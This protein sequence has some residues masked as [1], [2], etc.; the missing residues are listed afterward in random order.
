MATTVANAG[1]ST[2]STGY[3]IDEVVTIAGGGG[4]ATFKVIALTWEKGAEKTSEHPHIASTGQKVYELVEVVAATHTSGQLSTAASNMATSQ[5]AYTNAVTAEASSK[6]AYNSEVTNCV[7]PGLPSN[8]YLRGASADDIELVTLN[9]YTYVLNKKKTVALKDDLTDPVSTDAFIVIAVTA[10]NSKYEVIINGV[11]ITYT[12]AEDAG[13]GDAD[14]T[15]IVSNLVTGINGAGGAAASCVATAVGPGIHVTGVTSIAVAGGPQGGAIYSFINQISDISLL[16]L[17]CVHNYKVKVIN[18]T[19]IDADDMWVRFESGSSNYASGTGSWVESNEPASKFKLDPSTMPHQLVRETDGSFKFSEIAWENRDV[20]DDVTNPVPSFVG[21]TI[22]NMFFF[23]NRFGLLSGGNVILSK[24]GS[25]YDFWAGSAMVAI[26]DDPIDISASSTK[27]VFL[28]YVKTTSAGLAM[29][30]DS[31]QFLLSTDSDILSPESAKVNTLSDYECDTDIQA[32]NLGT[33][34]AFISKTPLY[35]RLFELANISTTDPPTSFN[36]TGIVP[37]LVPST[38]DNIAGSPGMSIISLGTTGSSTL[39]QYRFYQTAEKR[40]ASTWYKWDLTGNLIDQFFD[41][42]TFYTVISDGTNVSIMS[43]DLRQASDEGFL[44]LS[45]GEKT[46]VCMDYY[47][48]NPYR[49]YHKD[50][51]GSLSAIDANADKT[52][53]YLPFTHHTGKTLAVVALGGYIGGTLGATEAS[54]GA[55][56]YPTVAGSAG[57]EYVDISGDYR[58]KNIIIGYIYT[59]TVDLPK[60]Y[61][62]SGDPQSGK[63]DYTS[64]LIIHRV[65]ISTGLSGPVKYNVNLTGI[66]DRSQTVSAIMPY[67][68]TANDVAMAA[69]GVHEV[70]VYQR[71]ENIS[72]SIVGDTPLPVSLLGMTWEGKYNNKFYSHV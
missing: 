35:T 54:V 13:A 61:Y 3:K 64:D 6:T 47:A 69:E 28:N 5:T 19:N 42:S 71:N 67:T 55:V 17:Q 65:K 12:T 53:V 68:Y 70:P 58:G 33:S 63:A 21:S 52:R 59:M 39:Y 24:A 30:S 22:R 16:P 60:F 44:T 23:R 48:T 41:V 37:E 43:F 7:I 31:E 72:F 49:R 38:V 15:V 45:T 10:Y 11:S 34:L 20:G 2:S 27:P 25:F 9:D 57:S 66:P 36:T 4:N 50:T 56:L 51:S 29:F 8:G 1:G 18:S 62:N 46:D 26:P 14:A 40:I 32:I